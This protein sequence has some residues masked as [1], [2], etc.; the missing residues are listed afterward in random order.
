MKSW[1]H[2]VGDPL[3]ADL[4]KSPRDLLGGKATSLQ[5]LREAGLPVPPAFVISVDAC[6]FFLE[7]EESWP[8]E[9]EAQVKSHL[10]RLET[11]AGRQF[12][13][14]S[15]PLLV[16]VRSGAAVSM[17]GMMDT[18]LNV[19]LHHRWVESNGGTNDWSVF[20]QFIRN[21]AQIVFGMNIR[22]PDSALED[23]P[24][25]LDRSHVESALQQFEEE[26]GSAFPQSPWEIL[27]CS[28]NAVFRSWNSDRAIQYRRRHRIQG[29]KGTAVTIQAM[30]PSRA[31][32]IVF[33]QDPTD[34]NADRMVIEAS[35]GLGEAVV[36]GGTDPDRFV[37]QREDLG[38]VKT[39][40]GRKT[41]VILALRE[42]AHF[43]ADQLC[44]SEEELQQLCELSLKVEKHF[45]LPMDIEF[46]FTGSELSLLQ[47]RPIRGLD[48]ARD[49]EIGREEEIQR[50]K[51]LSIAR[52]KVW[53][54][55]NIGETLRFPT[56]LTWDF[57][58]FF[59]SG[60]GGFGKLYRDLG[61][62]PSREVM[63][64]G[65]LELIGGRIYA[66]P[67][68]L[69]GLFWDD[70]PMVYDRDQIRSDP[71][72]LDQGPQKFDPDRVDASFLF[73]VP[74]AIRSV[75]KCSR[76]TR[77]GLKTCHDFFEAECLPPFLEYIRIKRGQD[78]KSMSTEEVL[79]ELQERKQRVLGEFAAESLK[80]GFFGGLA[81]GQL[82]QRLGQ[83]DVND[84]GQAMAFELTLCADHDITL[85]QDALLSRVAVGEAN[86][87]EF[88]ERFGHRC[89]GEM[90]L[91]EP[92]WREDPDYLERLTVSMRGNGFDTT[93]IHRRNS[94]RREHA[95]QGLPEKLA[96][97]GGS[98]FLEEAVDCAETARRLLP[99]RESGK[100]YLMMGY[101]LIRTT[102]QELSRRWSIGS[103]VFF[104]KLNELEQ[105]EGT[106]D[107]LLDAVEHRKLRWQ[108]LQRLDMAAVIDSSDL[109]N[110]GRSRAHSSADTNRLEAAPVSPGVAEGTAEIVFDPREFDARK[111]GYIL[112]CPS[113]DPAWTPLFVNARGLIVER[114]GI[115]SHGAIVARDFG[116]PAVVCANATQRIVS[117]SHVRID[118]THGW[119]DLMEGN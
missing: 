118:G 13:Q 68:R 23:L 18:L 73:K 77:R 32:G 100:Y 102:I 79:A 101:E 36:S 46:G 112:V 31:S 93:E 20:L 62:V 34:P 81:L 83:L 110:L 44:L 67:D 7:H 29:L 17:P 76:A 14:G 71:K 103:N 82:T 85:E 63:A 1:V 33:T 26:A 69:A 16:S 8:P 56:P 60:A 119:V 78:L 111:T 12:G 55:H 96:G 90:E 40:P 107:E 37:V 6:E 27:E 95:L 74:Q 2:Y 64:D 59:M 72:L 9:L 86:M 66:D 54:A 51:N 52:P 19:G 80:P 35:Y 15:D 45:G 92:R 22:K 30:F 11:E 104:L 5:D 70:L 24:Q 88:L 84:E 58:K 114:G 48:V 25:D 98:S 49:S 99:Y 105:F 89:V 61:Y 47:A 41:H 50:L 109:E 106:P 108:S 42:E 97:W 115:L 53:V 117:G 38:I 39:T 87:D 113:T 65:F 4:E 28:I 57:I 94:E 116:I 91:M 21:Y 43:D 75:L 10:A 3:P